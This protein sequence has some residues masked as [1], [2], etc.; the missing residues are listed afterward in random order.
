[1]SVIINFNGRLG[2]DA[3][4]KTASNG[5][6]YVGFPIATNNFVNGKD[7]TI[8]FN[9]TDYSDRTLKLAQYLTKGKLVNIC[10]NYSD[11]TYTNKNNEIM[12][13]RK[14]RA[15]SIDFIS[16]GKSNEGDSSQISVQVQKPQVT[17]TVSP[18]PKVQEMA[19]PKMSV[20]FSSSADEIDDLPF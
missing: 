17:Q 18:Q 12:V 3:E 10:G 20:N 5:S 19:L 11:G 7:E 14:V 16:V 9:V 2:R 4:I 8:W 13:D 15:L 6:Q 1:M